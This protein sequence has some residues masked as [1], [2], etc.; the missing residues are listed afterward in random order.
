[1]RHLLVA[2]AIAAL[3]VG[4]CSTPSGS[5]HVVNQDEHFVRVYNGRQLIA[6]VACGGTAEIQ[7]S[8]VP[9]AQ[10]WTLEVR[11]ADDHVIGTA[12]VTHSLPAALVVSGASILVTDWPVV[13]GPSRPSPDPCAT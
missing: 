6:E 11:G 12:T 7:P 10:P 13:F 3:T 4:A 1:M 8:A 9:N 5:L 2:G